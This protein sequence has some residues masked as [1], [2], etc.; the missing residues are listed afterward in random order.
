[1]NLIKQTL[2]TTLI[3]IKSLDA[4]IL[5]ADSQTSSGSLIANRV[6]DKISI[7]NDYVVCCRSGAA[8][9]TQF[10]IDNLRAIIFK[11]F[12]ET[13][14]HL[15]IRAVVQI[16]REICYKE[17]R[18]TNYGFICAGWDSFNGNQLYSISQGGAVIQ[19]ALI[20]AGSGSFFIQSFCDSIYNDK[21]GIF[22]SRKFILKSISLAMARDGNTGGV[23]KL[24]TINSN[25]IKKEVLVPVL[26][27]IKDYISKKSVD[28]LI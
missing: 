26:K 3:G 11:H 27:P 8:A 16:L 9:D 19:Q 12:N 23:I 4:V 20:L 25:G 7:I 15:K 10:I 14:Q 13:R 28:Y 17:K 22:Q 1:M 21:M 2:G 24:C 5:A 18:Q 6:A